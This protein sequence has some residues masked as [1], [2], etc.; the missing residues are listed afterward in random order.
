MNAVS[1]L[2]QPELGF[3]MNFSVLLSSVLHTDGHKDQAGRSGFVQGVPEHA[4]LSAFNLC[5]PK[6]HKA[7]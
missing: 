5:F 4:V 1:S 7:E 3:K 6:N 2:F